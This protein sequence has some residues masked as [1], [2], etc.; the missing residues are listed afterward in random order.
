[1]HHVIAVLP[2]F[3]LACLVIAALPGPATALFLHR[4]LRDG[5]RCG[6]AAVAGNEIGVFSWALAAAAGLTALLQAN[7]LLFDALHI[8]GGLVLIWLG[9]SAWRSARRG[10]E[11][12]ETAPRGGTPRGVFRAALVSIAANPKAAVFA[13]SFFPQFLPRHGPLL[14]VVLALAVIQV[15]LDTVW[16]LGIVLLADRARPLLQRVAIRRRIERLLGAVLVAL[17]IELA[18]DTR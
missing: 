15:T 10:A 12:T 5:R 14:E 16:C 17:G 6:L 18:I 3:T 1:V 2:E 7:R 9:I 11:P 13:I 8:A 4:T